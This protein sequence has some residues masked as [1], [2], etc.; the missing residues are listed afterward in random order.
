MI[1]GLLLGLRALSFVAALQAAGA[2]VFQ[3][4]FGAE[5]RRA[6]RPVETW[7]ARSAVVALVTVT[8]YQLAEP[9]GLTGTLGG[10]L[11]GS[12][13]LALLASDVGTATSIRIFGLLLIAASTL[14]ATRFSSS[15]GLIGAVLT[16]VS[17]GFTGHTSA[18]DDRWFLA[19]LL[20]VHLLIVVFWFGALWPFVLAIRHETLPITAQ[21]I[22]RFSTL[23]F[24][25]VPLIFAAGL[26]IAFVLLPDLHAL[27]TRYGQLLLIKAAAFALLMGLAAANKWRFGPGVAAGNGEALNAFRRSVL[28]EWCLVAS[29]VATT[30]FMTGLFS[31]V[32]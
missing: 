18:H 13:Q 26:L 15:L 28:T 6:A 30:A 17:F 24:Y 32:H 21:L 14:R 8:L 5:L 22:E 10:V 4:L 9:A 1:D 27:R 12:L 19:P 25:L 23:A 31:P 2:G 20:M 29:V 3:C 7:A 11:D 16:V